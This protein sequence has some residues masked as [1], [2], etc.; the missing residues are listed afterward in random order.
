LLRN[1]RR[2][3]N[4]AWLAAQRLDDEKKRLANEEIEGPQKH[5][6]ALWLL[7]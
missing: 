2:V 3:G 6:G 4:E 5:L 7:R 1:G